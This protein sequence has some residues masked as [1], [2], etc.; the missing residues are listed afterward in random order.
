MCAAPSFMR[1]KRV[2]TPNLKP[3]PASDDYRYR[4]ATKTMITSM[5]RF[6]LYLL[7]SAL[8]TGFALAADDFPARPVKVLMPAAPG[9]GSDVLGRALAEEVSK[10][11]KQPL[12]I[13][14]RPGGQ[15]GSV[16]TK[17]F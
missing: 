6:I 4:L 15:G 9:T 11:L 2:D 5:S 3:R 17:V 8:A 16:A 12:V 10:R 7:A 1:G 13:D 14:N